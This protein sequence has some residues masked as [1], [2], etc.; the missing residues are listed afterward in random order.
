MSLVR[1][2]FLLIA[3]SLCQPTLAQTS[4][5]PSRVIPARAIPVPDTVSPPM[6]KLIARPPLTPPAPRSAEEWKALVAQASQFEMTRIADLR[7]HVD[8]DVI[9][10]TIAGVRCYEVIP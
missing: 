4:P 6:R 7:R 10:R 9:E 1:S 5:E 8:V 3:L 2:F